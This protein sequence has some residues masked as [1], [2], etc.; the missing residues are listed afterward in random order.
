MTWWSDNSIFAELV[1]QDSIFIPLLWNVMYNV[2]LVFPVQKETIIIG[3]ADYLKRGLA[4]KVVTADVKCW[5]L[6]VQPSIRRGKSGSFHVSAL[7]S[8]KRQNKS[9]RNSAKQKSY[10]ILTL[11]PGKRIRFSNVTVVYKLRL[12]HIWSVLYSTV[13]DFV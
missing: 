10:R 9:H 1:L 3:F 4:S 2:A 7:F 13:C 12:D 8:E 11:I 5:R 6:E